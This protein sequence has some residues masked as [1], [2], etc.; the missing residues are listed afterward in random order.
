MHGYHLLF[1]LVPLTFG[2]VVLRQLVLVRRL[3]R[4]GLE[5]VGRVVRQR[6]V[7]SRSGTHLVPTIGFTM[8]KL[9]SRS[10]TY[11]VP[12]IGFTTWLG[13]LIEAESAGQPT[14]L[15]FF[16]GD[17]VV[18]Y[19]DPDKPAR[20]LLAQELVV[21]SKYWKLALAVLLVAVT[22]AGHGQ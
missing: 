13:Q 1:S 6:E 8:Q 11:F 16:D 18:V 3:R 20:F 7:R 4:V 22:W 2:V 15:E 9:R 10:G 14:G 5:V 17:E 19:Y 12:T 21:T